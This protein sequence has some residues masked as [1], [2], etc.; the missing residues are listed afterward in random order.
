[1][2]MELY[3]PLVIHVLAQALLGKISTLKINGEFPKLLM[4]LLNFE[5]LSVNLK[6][7]SVKTDLYSLNLVSFISLLIQLKSLEE[8]SMHHVPQRR[9][10]LSSLCLLIF[11][12]PFSQI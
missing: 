5:K 7:L 8:L 6:K 10:G 4:Y 2:D 3:S 1:M 12:F 9:G 11:Y